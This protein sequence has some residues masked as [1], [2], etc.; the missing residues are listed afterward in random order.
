MN[1]PWLCFARAHISTWPSH[2]LSSLTD[3]RFVQDKM[4]DKGWGCAYRSLQ[5]IWSWF[6]LQH[7]TDRPVPDHRTI[8]QTLVDIGAP[9]NLTFSYVF[10]RGRLWPA[11]LRL[12]QL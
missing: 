7:Y 12:H 6:R 3:L 5:T 10:T 8:Q 9:S 4:D 2:S 11:R 1:L